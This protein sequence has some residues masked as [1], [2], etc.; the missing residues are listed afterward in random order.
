M[1]TSIPQTQ[2]PLPLFQ[3]L[4]E[5]FGKLREPLPQQGCRWLFTED[6]LLTSPEAPQRLRLTTELSPPQGPPTPLSSDIRNRL[7]SE[8]RELLQQDDG[9]RT[10]SDELR[11]ALVKDLNLLLQ[12]GQSLYTR[13]RFPHVVLT[14][15]TQAMLVLAPEGDDLV[16]LNRRL[17]EEAYPEAFANIYHVHQAALYQH[18]HEQKDEPLAALCFSGGGIRSATFNLGILQGLADHKLLE[19]FDYLSTVSGGGYVGSWF[20][21]WIY[22]HPEGRQGVIN[23]L[24]HR[25]VG[26]YEKPQDS[27]WSMPETA[28]PP[29]PLDPEPAPIRHLRNYSNYMT[30]RLGLL[31]ADTWTLVATYLRNLV[32]NWFVLVPLLGALLALPRLSVAF[33]RLQPSADWQWVSLFLGALLTIVAIGYISLSLPSVNQERQRRRSWTATQAGFLWFCLAPLITAV[34]LLT[35]YWAWRCPPQP[36]PWSFLIFGTLVHLCGWLPYAIRL[37]RDRQY[38]RWWVLGEFVLI[39]GMGALGGGIVWWV[40]T[41]VPIFAAPQPNAIAYACFAAPLLLTLFLLA[42]TLFVGLASRLTTDDDREWWARAGAWCLIAIVVWSVLSTLVNFGPLVFSTRFNAVLTSLG[43]LSG[44]F[45]LVAGHS[46]K[47]SATDKSEQKD[48]TATALLRIALPLA[49]PLF[50]LFLIILLSLGTTILLNHV[51]TSSMMEWIPSLS[52]IDFSA[53]PSPPHLFATTT[54]G[55]SDHLRTIYYAPLLL[56]VALILVLLGVGLVMGYFVNINK[57]SLH[58]TYRNRLIRAYLGATQETRNPHLFTGFD[59]EDNIQMYELTKPKETNYRVKPLHV[60]NI[61]LNL[62]KGGRLAWQQRKAESFTVSPLHCGSSRLGYRRAGEYGG[63]KDE[64]GDTAGISLGTAVAVSGAAASPNMGYHSSPAVTFL[65]ALFNV[66]LGWWLGNPGVAGSKTFRQRGPRFSVWPLIKETFGLTND[67]NKYVYLSDGG[68]FENLGL[69]E[70]VL[71]RCRYIVVIDAGCD[72]DHEFTDLGNAIRKIRIDLGV[73]IEIEDL[74]SY[75]RKSKKK[76]ARCA[77]GT[78]RYSC[79]DGKDTD[80]TLVYLKPAFYETD[81]PKDVLN[82]ALTSPTFPHEST[83]DQWFSESQFESYRMLG[84]HTI[85]NLYP[86][87]EK[88]ESKPEQKAGLLADLVTRATA[89]IQEARAIS[90]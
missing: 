84:L 70:M 41:Q 30:P 16:Q 24:K 89:G 62:V 5:E 56:I 78:I 63:Q 44:L 88:P 45:T 83:A 42:M 69:Y 11:Q 33:V 3:V 64:D 34:A 47:S 77:V 18:I 29:A 81:E 90:G 14:S 65:L 53:Q 1:T 55:P 40:V 17:L 87:Q 6:Q 75:S 46:A 36:T 57:F 54:D 72:P 67:Q 38:F 71:R 79:I 9:T 31:S 85:E 10:P 86:K 13:E 48:G 43:G 7:S 51:A 19:H 4:E 60:V 35:S 2:L 15:E 68:H 39:L 22:R 59:P 76:G 49:A 20:T 32:L 37:C 73:P 8:T 52:K 23:A 21:S 66:R 82:Y 50:A 58:A 28:P 25:A 12:S 80:G 26:D 27:S 74:P 61:A